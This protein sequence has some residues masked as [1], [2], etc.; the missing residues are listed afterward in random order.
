MKVLLHF[1][2]FRTNLEF[3]Q[4]TNKVQF[5]LSNMGKKVVRLEKPERLAIWTK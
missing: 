2:Y 1:H 5:G 4:M 3:L